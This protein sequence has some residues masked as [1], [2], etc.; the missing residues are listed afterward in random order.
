[1]A[2]RQY[3]SYIFLYDD[4]RG[5]TLLKRHRSYLNALGIEDTPTTR[6]FRDRVVDTNVKMTGTSQGLRHLLTYV[7]DRSLIA[8]IPYAPGDSKLTEHIEEILAIQR[9]ICGDYRG[10]TVITSGTANSFSK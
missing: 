3:I 8:K 4:D 1:M 7:D 10:E 5:A 6:L 2:S 9:V